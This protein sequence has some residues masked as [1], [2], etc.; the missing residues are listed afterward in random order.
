M[1][2]IARLVIAA[3]AVGGAYFLFYQ[4]VIKNAEN[5]KKK[6]EEPCLC[7]NCVGN[8][9]QKAAHATDGEAAEDTSDAEAAKEPEDS[10]EA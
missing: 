4:F 3:I 5:Q 2:I 1:E 10:K 9:E 8:A 7:V 6:A